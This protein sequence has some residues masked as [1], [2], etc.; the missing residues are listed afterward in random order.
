MLPF[1]SQ[2]TRTKRKTP[3]ELKLE[4]ASLKLSNEQLTKE[5]EALNKINTLKLK[6]IKRYQL[7]LRGAHVSLTKLRKRLDLQCVVQRRSK[8]SLKESFNMKSQWNVK[9]KN[10]EK[11]SVNTNS[12]AIDNKGR[13]VEF[14]AKVRFL[15][16]TCILSFQ[17][18]C[19]A[20]ELC[21]DLFF[22]CN[23]PPD[24]IP[25]SINSVDMEQHTRR[26]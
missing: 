13:T 15:Q 21:F 16:H 26:G 3:L 14:L 1:R 20:L 22:G 4:L 7:Q 24:F 6:Q 23:P 10:Q 11:S 12:I 5:N 19:L 25:I 17:K 9:N 18:T 2:V 8:Y